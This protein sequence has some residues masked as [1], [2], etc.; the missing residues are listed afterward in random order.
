MAL[1][2]SNKVKKVHFDVIMCY[3]KIHMNIVWFPNPV[4]MIFRIL[5]GC[6]NKFWEYNEERELLHFFF[7]LYTIAI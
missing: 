5:G 4:G 6:Q 2:P 7:L 3:S 1:Q